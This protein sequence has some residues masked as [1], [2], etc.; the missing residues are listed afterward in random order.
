MPRRQP[1]QH[2]QRR[3]CQ[4]RRTHLCIV[5]L[6]CCRL[7]IIAQSLSSVSTAANVRP[8]LGQKASI[9]R[10]LVLRPRLSQRA[11]AAA[12]LTAARMGESS[13]DGRK[14]TM[15]AIGGGAAGYFGAIQGASSSGGKLEVVVLEAGRLPLQKVKVSGGGRCN[16]MHDASK[17]GVGVGAF[18]VCQSG[19]VL[20]CRPL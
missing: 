17:V 7:V 2:Q 5:L 16:V 1:P 14:R 9:G 18:R 10:R 13:L 11:A 15:V 12:A 6:A 4:R 20:L 3:R 8:S 19:P